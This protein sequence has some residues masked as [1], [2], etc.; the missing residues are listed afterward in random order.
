MIYPSQVRLR[1]FLNAIPQDCF[2][3]GSTWVL[4]EV[5]GPEYLRTEMM[6][7]MMALI[8]FRLHVVNSSAELQYEAQ[9][10]LRSRIPSPCLERYIR[11]AKLFMAVRSG[12]QTSS[13]IVIRSLMYNQ[14]L[15]ES[16]MDPSRPSPQMRLLVTV[17]NSR[18][19]QLD[20]SYVSILSPNG[21]LI[22]INQSINTSDEIVFS[23]YVNNEIVSRF[24][25][26]GMSLMDGP[27]RLSAND[28]GETGIYVFAPDTFFFE[29]FAETLRLTGDP[30]TSNAFNTDGVN[31]AVG[32]DISPRLNIANRLRPASGAELS[33]EEKFVIV[34]SA[35][36]S[37]PYRLMPQLDGECDE[38][39]ILRTQCQ[40][41]LEDYHENE[42]VR[43]LPCMH[44]FHGSCVEDWLRVRMQC[45]NCCAD[46]VEMLGN[47]SDSPSASQ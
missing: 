19:G 34:M 22:P 27:L 42:P 41:C 37:Y 38:D 20:Q 40:I 16:L 2:N 46:L 28:L 1:S 25:T 30:V 6:Y 10:F 7:M 35:L 9:E 11:D 23:I 29:V 32:G 21:G 36:P 45:P 3:S 18:I 31:T 5:D 33:K 17:C 8:E 13:H 14:G 24:Q 44:V 4:I 39:Y 15:D 12:N 43:A 26:I 47:P